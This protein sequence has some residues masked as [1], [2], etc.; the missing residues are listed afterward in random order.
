MAMVGDHNNLKVEARE[1]G[2]GRRGRCGALKIRL[3]SVGQVPLRCACC[4][5]AGRNL[6]LV[7]F[8]CGYIVSII[9]V[10]RHSVENSVA[11]KIVSVLYLDQ[12][13]HR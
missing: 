1:V 4:V 8:V 9:G 13:D 6:E 2:F 3:D 12:D 11:V 5:V 10:V 7:K